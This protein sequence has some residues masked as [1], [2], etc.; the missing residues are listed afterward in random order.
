MFKKFIS[1][2]LIIAIINA[3]GTVSVFAGSNS[4]KE[5]RRAV[6][7]REHV[8]RLGTGD[9]AKI[10]ITLKDRSKIEGYVS[11]A[12]ENSFAVTNPKTGQTTDIEYREVKKAKGSNL[13]TGAKIAIG[14][15][16][17]LVILVIAVLANKD[18]ECSVCP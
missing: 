18:V 7:V 15:G 5:I 16:I 9:A 14:V 4:E 13:S 8:R 2:A 10:K 6:K 17:G 3:L 12:G 11:R 1:I